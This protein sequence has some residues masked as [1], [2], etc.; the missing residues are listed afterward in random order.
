MRRL[1]ERGQL[2]SDDD[3][4]VGPEELGLVRPVGHEENREAQAG[5]EV[6]ELLDRDRTGHGVKG[7]EGLVE[8]EKAGP[9]HDRA[10]D[11]GP[12]PFPARERG[13]APVREVADLEAFEGGPGLVPGAAGLHPPRSQAERD[14]LEHGEVREEGVVLGDERDPPRFGGERRQVAPVQQ[15]PPGRGGDQPRDRLEKG[16]LT[17]T[18]RAD[19]RAERP[20]GKV[21]GDGT[22]REAAEPDRQGIK[23]ERAGRVVSH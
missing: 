6:R 12:L 13:R 17:R 18:R 5:M 3:G 16:R 8:E 15:Q 11:R 10:S 20:R 7:G 4:H 22:Q 21:E 9:K 19:D 14:V 2:S 23:G 1:S